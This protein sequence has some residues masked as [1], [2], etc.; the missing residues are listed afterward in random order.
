MVLISVHLGV[1]CDFFWLHAFE[2]F[3]YPFEMHRPFFYHRKPLTQWVSDQ[4]LSSVYCLLRLFRIERANRSLGQ[5]KHKICI[6]K[7]F[8][9]LILKNLGTILNNEKCHT[10]IKYK[11]KFFNIK[12]SSQ[13]PETSFSEGIFVVRAVSTEQ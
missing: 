2:V 7:D 4:N 9:T 10:I 3:F 1:I 8:V 13:I 11:K 12:P 6:F 5:E